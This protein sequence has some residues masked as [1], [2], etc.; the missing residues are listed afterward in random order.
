MPTPRRHL[1][2][3][4]LLVA[5]LVAVLALVLPASA[6]SAHAELSTTD[7]ADGSVVDQAPRSVTL[8]FT[9]GVSL[10]P[11][12]VRVLDDQG[13]RVDVGDASSSGDT[14]DVPLQ[15]KLR[16]GSYVVA[17]RVVSADG[18]PVHGAFSFSVGQETTIE[19]GLAGKAFGRGSDRPYEIAAAILRVIGYAAVF[20]ASGFVLVG[21][22]LRRHG[23][24]S[25]VG[26]RTAWVAAIGLAALLLQIP[27]QA[28]LA[29]G[30]G[31]GS[32]RESAVLG[33]ALGEGVGLA[34]LVTAAGLL[35][36]LITKGLPFDDVAGRVAVGGALVAPLGFA[37]SGHTRTISPAGLGIVAD[38]AHALAAAIWFG[39]LAAVLVAVR[40]RRDEDDPMGAAESIT[41][42][43]DWAAITVGLVAGTGLLLAW[44]EVGGLS[45]LTSTTYGRLL[46]A[47]VATVG[48][49]VVAAGW[50]RIR[51]VPAIA[52]AAV[53][54]PPQDHP[55][56]WSR[57]RT[58]VRAEI[59]LLIVV[60]CL[61]GVLTNVTPAVVA[62]TSGQITA[63]APLGEGTVDITVDPSQPGR[64]DIHA[65]ILD[66][67]GRPDDR[68]DEATFSLALP[69]EDI[70]PLE[71][72][73]V[74][75][76]PGH[77]QLVATQLSLAGDWEITIT[78]KPDRFTEQS[79]TVTVPVR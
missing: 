42:F 76:G 52:A 40:R 18:H 64:N 57:L 48:L 63:S 1:R 8:R 30:R 73:P 25:P 61:T 65:Y 7:P 59:G 13:D 58:T 34:L 46:L 24:P 56:A 69:A 72:T 32:V 12:G 5:L 71:R 68:Y 77:F 78:V 20:A 27:V 29:T 16:R 33:L 75:A 50:N 9:E 47:K 51:L 67:D 26:S 43:S 44:K 15:E 41:R 17:W 62:G 35:A 4:R 37:L 39:G 54:D 36:I 14:V 38:A 74:R 60:L 3:A 45:A 79:A 2:S 55:A 70:G 31:L 10:R 66:A 23:E 19:S 28:A 53:A 22:R 11:D 6:A 49:V 21:A